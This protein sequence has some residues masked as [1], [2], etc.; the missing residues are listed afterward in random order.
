MEVWEERRVSE[1]RAANPRSSAGRRREKRRGSENRR[2]RVSGA[3]TDGDK[4]DRRGAYPSLF[5]TLGFPVLRGVRRKDSP[6]RGALVRRCSV[7]RSTDRR[8]P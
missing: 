2:N 8:A 6:R 5:A 1:R 3:R 7:R 4:S